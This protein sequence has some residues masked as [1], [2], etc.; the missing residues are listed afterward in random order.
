MGEMAVTTQNDRRKFTVLANGF[1]IKGEGTVLPGAR[2]TDY[3]N[4]SRA[5]VAL[6]NAQVWHVAE[7]RKLVDAPFLNINRS[8]VEIVIPENGP[9]PAPKAA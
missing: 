4:N 9:L 6:T 5:F 7:G 2:V 3:L 1:Q 8:C